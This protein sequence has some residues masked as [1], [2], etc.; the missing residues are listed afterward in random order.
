MIVILG[1]TDEEIEVINKICHVVSNKKKTDD[2][3]MKEV[4]FNIEQLSIEEIRNL[5]KR[6]TVHH[7]K[8]DESVFY[9]IGLRRNSFSNYVRS[10]K[11]SMKNRVSCS[12]SFWSD[13]SQG[14][15]NILVSVG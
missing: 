13:I 7:A 11:L 8:Y 14:F 3:I 10:F 5:M 9:R 15:S 6:W 2:S 4:P 1:T 12:V